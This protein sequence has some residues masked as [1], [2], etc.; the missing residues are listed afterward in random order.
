MR[1]YTARNLK[2]KAK[3]NIMLADLDEI[4]FKVIISN[5]FN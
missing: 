3:W 5:D 4:D 2:K 1:T